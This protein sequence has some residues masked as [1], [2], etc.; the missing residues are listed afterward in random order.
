MAQDMAVTTT[1][2]KNPLQLNN[3]DASFQSLDNDPPELRN[4]PPIRDNPEMAETTSKRR[5]SVANPHS[6]QYRNP[7][8]DS[9]SNENNSTTDED[10]DDEQDSEY[11]DDNDD[12]FSA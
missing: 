6:I 12:V 11:D 4:I 3:E 7:T 1:T 10:G 5:S 9:S 2:D 8:H